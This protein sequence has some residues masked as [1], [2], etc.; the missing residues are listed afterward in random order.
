MNRYQPRASVDDRRLA[1]LDIETISG[2]E[3]EDGGFP[4]WPTHTPVVASILTA[5]RDAHGE[6]A[7]A[8]KSIRFGEHEHPFRRLDELLQG[9][10]WVTFNGRGFNLPVLMLTAQMDRTFK[11]PAL[12]AAATA[13]RFGNAV[14]YDLAERYSNYGSARGASLEMLCDGL[15]IPAKLDTHGDDVGKLYDEG[16]IEAIEAYCCQDV[17]SALLLW[18]NCRAM[19]IGDAAYH[20]SLTLPVRP[21]G[22]DA[23]NRSSGAVRRS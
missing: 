21:V 11:L 15:G 23:G 8:I 22:R 1:V 17:A 4:P 19:E 7:F 12:T 14:H 9:R 13:P 10:T 2:E 6:W 3:M 16:N 18:A 5:D 20:A